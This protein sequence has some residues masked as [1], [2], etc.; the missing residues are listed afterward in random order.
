MAEA[1]V[2]YLPKNGGRI[3]II[4]SIAGRNA[5]P[6]IPLYCA[7][8]AAIEGFTRCW[9]AEL[10]PQGHTVNQVNPGAVDTDMLKGLGEG[11]KAF[12]ENT[13]FENRF[14]LPQDIADVVAFLV[15]E[16]SRWITGQ[17]ISASGGL[18]ILE[19]IFVTVEVSHVIAIV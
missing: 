3:I 4:G 1:V 14:G 12:A 5:V 6:Q 9:A 11:A 17:V 8:K 15:D 13:P 19:D 7:S 2:P 10:G 16:S 18:R